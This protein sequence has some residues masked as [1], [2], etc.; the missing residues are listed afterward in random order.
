MFTHKTRVML[1]VMYLQTTFT[2]NIDNCTK[3]AISHSH[4][5][6][7][8]WLLAAGPPQFESPPRIFRFRVRGLPKTVYFFTRQSGH[9][10]L[11][12]GRDQ[13]TH[14][15]PKPWCFSDPNHVVL[16]LK[17]KAEHGYSVVTRTNVK[18]RHKGVFSL[19]LSATY[20]ANVLWWLGW[21]AQGLEVLRDPHWDD[22]C[23]W[24]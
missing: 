16:C 6:L 15:M 19:I 1:A 17:L 13:T 22:S 23:G 20:L 11:R 10:Q 24:Y 5:L 7:I 12:R 4:H 8:S 21:V 14:F 9:L 2:S 3:R 18:L